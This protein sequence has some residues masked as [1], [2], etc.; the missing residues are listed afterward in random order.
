[1]RA[2]ALRWTCWRCKMVCQA[3]GTSVTGDVHFCPK[4]GVPMVAAQPMYAYPPPQM[5]MYVPRVQ[6]H[7]QT[8]GILWCVFG[9]YRVVSGLI[10]MF[11][12]KVFAFHNFRGFDWPLNYHGLEHSWMAAM[13]PLIAAYTIVT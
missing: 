2:Q 8:L 4:C 13:V 10:G 11:F 9:A 7:L 1:M 12:F 3:C 6:R 5:P